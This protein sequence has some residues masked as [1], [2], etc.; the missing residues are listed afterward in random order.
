MCQYCGCQEIGPI[1]ALMDD[2][3]EIRNLCGRIRGHVLA[4]EKGEAVALVRE[5]QRTFGVHNSVEEGGLYLSM[6]R[7]EEYEEKAG[8]LYDEH[9]ALDEV[10]DD[11]L[12]EDAAGRT[13]GIDFAPLLAEFEILVEHINHEE[14]GLFPAAAVIL[15]PEDWTRCERL[16]DEATA[17][18]D[19]P[20]WAAQNA[21]APPARFE[22]LG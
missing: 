15:D 6:T 1:G 12:A 2:H 21:A 8:T 5:L 9:D 11:L 13:E 4:G 14:N 19:R 18:L 22:P 10:I 16:R 17:R 7:F 3:F 20:L